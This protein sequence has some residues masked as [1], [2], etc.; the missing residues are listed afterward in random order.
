MVVQYFNMW[1][2]TLRQMIA[3]YMLLAI[4]TQ[5]AELSLIILGT[6]DLMRSYND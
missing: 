6:L 4:G 2:T 1:T 5:G 3:I